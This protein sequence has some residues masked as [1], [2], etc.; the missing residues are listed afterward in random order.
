MADTAQPYEVLRGLDYPPHRRAEP[1]DIRDDLPPESIPWLLDQ[2]A[3][4]TAPKP[5]KPAKAEKE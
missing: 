5:K 3:I 2:G 4:R 1:G